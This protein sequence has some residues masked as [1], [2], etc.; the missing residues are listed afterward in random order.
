MVV[1]FL[2]RLNQLLES[3][4][5]VIVIGKIKWEEVIVLQLVFQLIEDSS[6]LI[7]F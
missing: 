5:G 1:W 7:R 4:G 2:R 3:V 6:V